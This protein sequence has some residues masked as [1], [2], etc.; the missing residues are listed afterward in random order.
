MSGWVDLLIFTLTF[1]FKENARPQKD[2]QAHFCRREK[3]NVWHV[4]ENKQDTDQSGAQVLCDRKI[5]AIPV[6]YQAGIKGRIVQYH[7]QSASKI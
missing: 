2:T 1:F 3:S 5:F 6:L 4:Q 7:P